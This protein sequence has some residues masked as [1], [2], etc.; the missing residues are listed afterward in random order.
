M[1]Q[2]EKIDY[3]LLSLR[4]LEK[5]IAGMRDAEIYPV[6]FFSQCFSLSHQIINDLHGLETAQLDELGRQIE[7]HRK[8]IESIPRRET[9]SRGAEAANSA[10][11][12]NPPLPAAESP[13][14]VHPAPSL[15]AAPAPEPQPPLAPEPVETPQPV[16]SQPM[17]TTAPVTTTQS[18]VP[19]QPVE[20]LASADAELPASS[21]A[22]P[23]EPS[24]RP[25]P[26]IPPVAES[27]IPE[28]QPEAE[29]PET[30]ETAE[31]PLPLASAPGTT[32]R[33]IPMARTRPVVAAHLTIGEKPSV[34]LNEVLEKKNLSDFRKAFSLNDR[35]RFR[36][37]LFGGDEEKMNR[38][39]RDLNDLHTF[40]DSIAYLHTELKWNVDDAA[41]AGFI[42]LLEKRF[43]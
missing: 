14:E 42:Q 3:L 31:T 8:L 34:S 13:A 20:T 15:T 6:S 5:L 21:T 33:E 16:V 18:I 40:E 27:T 28:N 36:R 2:K 29:W 19:S 39:I 23:A 12:A 1:A 43:S 24:I 11:P 35:F 37:E 38:A 4:E 26:E 7:A 17:A 22:Q 10:N 30:A 32:S 41:V 9:V 25:I